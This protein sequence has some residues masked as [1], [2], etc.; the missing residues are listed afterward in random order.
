MSLHTLG[1]APRFERAFT[2][3]AASED[4]LSPARVAREDRD[5]FLLIDPS[6]EHPAELAGRLRHA[7]RSRADLPAVGDWVAAHGAGGGPRTIVAVLPRAS[8]FVRKAAGETTEKQIVA[9]NVDTVFLVSG[10]DADLNPRR[11]ERYLASAWESGAEP[12]VVLNKSDLAAD[13]ADAALAI[14]VVAPGVPVLPVS[15][16]TGRGLE[17]LEPWLAP[18]RTVALLGS[19]G[20][21]KSTIVNALLGVERQATA[22]VRED[23]AR[24]RHTTARRELIVLPSGALLVDTPGMRELQLWGIEDGLDGTFPEIAALAKTCRFRDCRHATEPGCAVR[25]AVE[26]RALDPARFASWQKLQR[27]LEW[28]ASQKDARARA[29]R[30]A[31]WKAIH[32]SMK[33]HPKLRR[34]R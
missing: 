16:L 11:I 4:G 7:A 9:A 18:G 27:E 23:D 25:A 32:A 3:I 30:E 14:G 8:A 6:G 10:L 5:R 13:P 31:R 21:G 17:A 1:F 33:H 26:G 22:A 2:Q 12:V 15:A 24:G 19:S 28:L 29:A 34:D 20:V